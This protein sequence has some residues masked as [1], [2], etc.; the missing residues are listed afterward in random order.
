MTRTILTRTIFSA[1]LFACIM[2]FLWLGCP[3]YLMYQEQYQLFL[4]TKDYFINA[5]AVPGG[6]ADYLSEF[7]VQFFY[8]PLY[9][10]IAAA[11]ILT[12]AQVFLGLSCRK[13]DLA[14]TA[15]V[16]A[17]VPSLIFL[18]TFGDE[19]SLMS[20][21]VALMLTALFIFLYSL[22]KNKSIVTDILCL[23]VGFAILYW[24][25]GA[26]AI[27]FVVAGGIIGRRPLAAVTGV[28]SAFLIV[29]G[30]NMLW[31]EQYPLERLLKGLN[32]YR[33]PEIYPAWLYIIAVATLVAP[34]ISLIKAASKKARISFYLS[35][36]VVAAVAIF[37]VRVSF[38]AGKSRVLAYDSIFRQCRWDDI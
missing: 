22:V 1:V 35:V 32:Y 34:L 14:D 20:F 3:Q 11:I 19:N 29:W 8:V 23:V 26:F 13:C 24:I 17:S 9:G 4:F 21:A 31:I 16:V 12:L 5:I 7:A 2:L 28:V 25:A 15:Y 6:V 10:S 36:V 38:D 27:V 37:Y 33:V 18:G 30:I